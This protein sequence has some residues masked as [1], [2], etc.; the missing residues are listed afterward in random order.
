MNAKEQLSEFR[1]KGYCLVKGVY[2]AS[3]M[4]E[5]KAEFYENEQ[6]FLRVQEQ[7]GI[8]DQ[9]VDATHH[10]LV[11]CRK[12]LQLLERNKVS[13][14]LDEFFSP[15]RYILNTM[16]LSKIRPGGKVYT[17]KI[18][19]DVRTFQGATELWVNTLIMLDES[20]TDNGATWIMEGSEQ[21]PEK[22][23][24]EDFWANAI[25]VEGS[26]GDVLIFHGGVWHCAG[27]NRTEKTR[28]IITP[29]YSAPFIKQQLDYPRAFGPDFGESCSDYLKQLLGY[30]ALVPSSLTEFYQP[31]DQ[32]FYKS[33]QG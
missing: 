11:L 16:G 17:Q 14:F 10:T 23:S 32:R 2:P 33:D 26:P 5:V 22:P 20:T 7:Q 4:E 21:L 3:L 13:C 19:R 15:K 9:V 29:F 18:H 1:S 12:M 27:Q 25:Q 8:A 31:D 24:D 6:A 30:N 28:H